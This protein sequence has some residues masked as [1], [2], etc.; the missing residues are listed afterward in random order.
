MLRAVLYQGLFLME[1]NI[2]YGNL[3]YVNISSVYKH[4]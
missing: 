1:S 4:L 2:N 3:Q